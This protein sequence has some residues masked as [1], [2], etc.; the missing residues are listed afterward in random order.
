MGLHTRVPR[1]RKRSVGLDKTTTHRSRGPLG[2][3]SQAQ[4]ADLTA[5]LK[6]HDLRSQENRDHA[7]GT[8]PSWTVS[9]A[10][11]PHGG[12]NLRSALLPP[13]P[14]LPR[15][16]KLVR[17]DCE[18]TVPGPFSLKAHIMIDISDDTN[19]VRRRA[20]VTCVVRRRHWSAGS[21][22]WQMTN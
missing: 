18:T 7:S 15:L 20:E 16:P 8:R 5:A 1:T 10:L 22:E 12:L 19:V 13:I 9:G 14:V 21:S 6:A 3:S 2:A 4:V 17:V 11:S